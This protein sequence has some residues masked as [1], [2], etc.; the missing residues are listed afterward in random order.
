MFPPAKKTMKD[1]TLINF[2]YS[3]FQLKSD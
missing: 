3:I 2:K 1:F